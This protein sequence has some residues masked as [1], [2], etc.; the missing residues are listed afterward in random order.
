[1]L[2]SVDVDYRPEGAVAA[3]IGFARWTD[4]APRTEVLFERRGAAAAYRPGAF[5]LRELP[6]ILGVLER[7]PE[8]PEVVVVDGYAWLGNGRKGLGAH[9]HAALAG[10]VAVIGVAKRPFRDADQAIGPARVVP[11]LRGR[12]RR[13]LLVTAVGM[14]PEQAAG[15]V[16]RMH[17]AYRIPTLLRY[18]DR[19]CREA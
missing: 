14:D 4:P 5:Y 13:P 8:T 16:A 17:G 7:L 19:L 6:P 3:C 2:A 18:V 9:L 12:S 11:V 10:A 1:M 15:C